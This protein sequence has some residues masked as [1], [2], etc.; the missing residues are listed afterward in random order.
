[1]KT[2]EQGKQR[3]KKICDIIKEE[4]L[5]PARQE[6]AGIIA[7]AQERAQAI[8]ADAEKQVEK[9]HGDVRETIE[10][11]RRIFHSSLVQASRQTLT[12]LK[13]EIEKNL[14]SQSIQEIQEKHPAEATLAAKLTE[15]IVKA[16]DRDGISADFS[17]AVSKSLSAKE[18]NA[19][20]SEHILSRLREKSVTLGNFASGIQVTLHDK[21]MMLDISDK[22]LKDLLANYVRKDFRKWI[23]AEGG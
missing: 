4:T 20:L 7:A 10:Q 18:V 22:V 23:F 9:I 14:F 5:E 2:L 15:A 17:V 1:M 3:I 8:I 12:L 16:I 13:Q 11:E 6:A 21:K 19:V